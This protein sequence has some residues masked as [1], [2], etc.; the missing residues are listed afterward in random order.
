MNEYAEDDKNLEVGQLQ[1][2]GKKLYVK[3]GDKLIR[4]KSWQIPDRK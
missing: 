2:R 1:R 4:L 3:C